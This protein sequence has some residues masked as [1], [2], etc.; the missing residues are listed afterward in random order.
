M[1]WQAKN[2]NSKKPTLGSYINCFS[3]RKRRGREIAIERGRERREI[4]NGKLSSR[5]KQEI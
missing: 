5:C 2:C 4:P 1:K 3:K